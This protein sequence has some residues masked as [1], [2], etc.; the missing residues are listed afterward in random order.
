MWGE[1]REEEDG[2]KALGLFTR[3][4]RL[5]NLPEAWTHGLGCWTP[6]PCS[7]GSGLVLTCPGP[8]VCPR[9]LC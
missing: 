5:Q 1:I 4:R 6:R 7:D 8:A 3:K 2:R 9:Q